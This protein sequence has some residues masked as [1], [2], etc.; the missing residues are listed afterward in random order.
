MVFA[1]LEDVTP[2]R[3]TLV[4]KE[5][6]IL[7]TQKVTMARALDSSVTDEGTRA[8]LLVHYD[9]VRALKNAPRRIFIK[10]NKPNAEWGAKEV[11]FYREIAPPMFRRYR[12]QDFPVIPCH[13]A[14]YDP[15]TGYSFVILDDISEHFK[16]A[17]NDQ[18]LSQFHYEK[19][20]EGLGHLHAFWWNDEHLTHHIDLP[21]ADALDSQLEAYQ[22]S[23]EVFKAHMR[24]LGRLG[25]G[26]QQ[27]LETVISKWPHNFRERL[28]TGK[29]VTIIHRDTHPNNF[30]YAPRE[31]KIVDW[32]SW[33]LG[34]GTTDLA[35]FIACFAPDNIRK[36]QE[37]RLVQRY[38]DTLLRLGVKKYTWDDCWN[39]Y[40]ASIGRCI[41]FL[42]NAWTPNWLRDDRWLRGERAIKAFEELDGMSLYG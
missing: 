5:H 33:R 18:P 38:Y 32:Q 27:I 15:D 36:F 9:D 22:A 1:R 30:M 40:R 11:R 13:V 37:K 16:P 10:I 12:P 31:V 35:Y 24:D 8:S 42:L 4:F 25:L 19:V 20:M 29:D 7:T 41:A 28:L 14:E 2:E 6:G 34:M 39:D 3:L 23:Y 21:T 17:R 26:Q